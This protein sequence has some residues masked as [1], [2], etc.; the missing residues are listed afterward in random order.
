MTAMSPPLRETEGRIVTFEEFVSEHQVALRRSALALTGNPHDADDLLQSTLVK[1]YLAWDR[2]DDHARLRSYAR[3]TMARTYVSLWRRWGRREVPVETLPDKAVPASDAVADRD[4]VWRALE[5][6]GRRQRAVVV[7][8]HFEDLDLATI[9]DTLGI[10]LGTA[11]S[12][13]SRGMAHLRDAL[14]GT[15]S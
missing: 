8:R 7:L 3:T 6:L 9:A 2:L 5:K 14:E 1:L 10:S 11:K 15:A 4:L 12:Q 13:L